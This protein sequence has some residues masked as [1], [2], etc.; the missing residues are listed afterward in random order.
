MKIGLELGKAE[1]VVSC[2]SHTLYVYASRYVSAC[3]ILV[4]FIFPRL[5][6]RYHTTVSTICKTVLGF[7]KFLNRVGNT[8]FVV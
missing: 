3:Y 8:V 1:S 7:F 4:I 5:N 2:I 6:L